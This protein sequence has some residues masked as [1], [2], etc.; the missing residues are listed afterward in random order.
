MSGYISYLCAPNNGDILFEDFGD[1]IV[2]TTSV[3]LRLNTEY[4]SALGCIMI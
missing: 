4:K 3:K 2:L 1:P